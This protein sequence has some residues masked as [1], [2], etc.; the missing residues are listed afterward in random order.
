[1]SRYGQYD[2]ANS[3]NSSTFFVYQEIPVTSA[4]LNTWNG[5]LAAAF[6]LLHQ[7]FSTL[8]SQGKSAVMTLSDA[9]PLQVVPTEPPGMTVQVLPGW[10]ILGNSLAGINETH[11]LPAG[12]A[13]S[14]PTTNPRID[15]MV[16]SPTG[17]LDILAGT[18]SV[19][20][21]PPDPPLGVISLARIHL[22]PG[23][24]Q[25][26][27]TDDGTQA[28]LQDVRPQLLLGEAH[29]HAPDPT[30][31]EIPDGARRQFSTTHVFREGSLEIFLNGILQEKDLDY[32]VSADR[33]SY[34]FQ[35]APLAHY[36]LQHRYVIEQEIT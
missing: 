25:I 23:V 18:E 10:A 4:K 16:L 33:R 11:L 3:E 31:T 32:V 6:E 14:A 12:G 2:P 26:L 15:L 21:V 27:S 1:M 8:L 28:Y 13:I 35:T 22:R 17:E 9:S 19:I 5:N 30:P 29:R 7:V 20:P 24:T 36:R 34:V